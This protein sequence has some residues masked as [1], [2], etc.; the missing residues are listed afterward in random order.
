MNDDEKFL[1]DLE[2]Y[3][4]LRNVLTADE[5]ARCNAAID[6]HRERFFETDRALEGESEV[7]GGAA[8]QK[9]MEGMLA[10][11]R[12]WCE[13]FRALMVHS[14]LKPYLAEVLGGAYR[15]DHGPLLIAMN[16]GEGGHLL[17]GGGVERQD[18]GTYLNCV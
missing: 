5:V 17:H 10:W 18:F 14:R 15:L 11:D 3:L 8:K 16:K 1:F 2:G 12:P 13:P 9:W 7:L 6:H 4:I